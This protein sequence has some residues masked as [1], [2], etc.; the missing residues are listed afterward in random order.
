MC[1][2]A[3]ESMPGIN[4]QEKKNKWLAVTL[5]SLIA[6]TA[7]TYWVAQADNTYR[8]DKQLFKNYDLSR[9]DEIWLE[10]AGQKT[11]LSFTGSRWKINQTYDVDRNMI[12]VLFATLDQVEPKRPVAASLQDS[13]LTALQQAGT[14]VTIR[15]EGS[16]VQTFYAG[17]NT[18]KN[19]AYFSSGNTVY[20][21]G[22]PG[23]RVYASGIF[24]LAEIDW[25]DKYVFWFNWQNFQ[26]LECFFPARPADDFSL[27][28]KDG[29]VVLPTLPM[30]DT[31]KLNNYLDDVSLLTVEAY[32]ANTSLLDSL[33][34]VD[35][36]AKIIV[37]DIAQR[38]YSLFLYPP[39]SKNQP[40]PVLLNGQDW[41]YLVP[42]RA[43]K[44][45]KPKGY[46]GTP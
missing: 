40:Y 24:E 31:T 10:R 6:I 15:M 45:I 20:L 29:M 12:D 33:K 25:R 5:L 46:F 16:T 44:V 17:G 34:G 14:Q 19:Q 8:V 2:C 13:T 26:R 36:L 35:P 32:V 37:T 1:I 27:M 38:Q 41:A 21:V 30:A 9:V 18:K 7:I 4:M 43:N 42:Q 3:K 11:T 22:I 39:T 28:M 23:Y